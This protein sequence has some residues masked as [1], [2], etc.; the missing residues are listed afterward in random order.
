MRQDRIRILRM[1]QARGTGPGPGA[2]PGDGKP[3]E[4]ITGPGSQGHLAGY[5]PRQLRQNTTT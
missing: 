3:G 1:L 2:A 4:E 5:F